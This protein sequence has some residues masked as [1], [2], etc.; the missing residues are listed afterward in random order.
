MS[1][2]YGVVKRQSSLGI[3]RELVRKRHSDSSCVGRE[4]EYMKGYPT[5]R[6]LTNCL[7]LSMLSKSAWAQELG[8]I[9]CVFRIMRWYLFISHCSVHIRYP[10]ISIR[11]RPPRHSVRLHC[12]CISVCPPP[13]SL[14]QI[15]W[16]WWETHFLATMISKCISMFP[17]SV[18]PGAP[19]TTLEYPDWTYNHIQRDFE[20]KYMPY[21]D[22]ANLVTVTMTNTIEEV[23]CGWGTL[24][25]KAVRIRH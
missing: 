19:P 22:G 13:A 18:S 21:Y 14:C 11:R 6:N 16:R 8:M 9:D 4:W 25:S 1:L 17:Q 5:R 10:C 7:D 3:R 24:R 23:P 15:D 12:H 2:D 20:I